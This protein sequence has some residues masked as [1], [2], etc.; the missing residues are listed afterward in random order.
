MNKD[1]VKDFILS[2]YMLLVTFAFLYLAYLAYIKI[3]PFTVSFAFFM[4]VALVNIAFLYARWS[5]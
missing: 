2:V 4:F 5:E 3:G 1:T